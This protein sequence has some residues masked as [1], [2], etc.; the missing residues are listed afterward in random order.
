M[1]VDLKIVNEGSGN[2]EIEQGHDETAETSKREGM[3]FMMV[4]T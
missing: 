1:Y 3:F 2:V 4:L